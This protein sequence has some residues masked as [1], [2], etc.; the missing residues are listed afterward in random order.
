MMMPTGERESEREEE[1]GAERIDKR[2]EV[3]RAANA[4]S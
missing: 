1:E 4:P 3:N 2:A